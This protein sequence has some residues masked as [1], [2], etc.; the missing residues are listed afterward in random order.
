[1]NIPRPVKNLIEAFERLPGIGPKTARR[2]AFYLLYVPESE[3]DLLAQAV[4]ELREKITFCEIC[5]NVDEQS[6]CRICTSHDRDRSVICV[7]EN[8][9]DVLAIEATTNYKGLYHVLHGVISP[10]N[11]IGPED[12]KVRE[13]LDRVKVSKYQR[14]KEVILAL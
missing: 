11:H 10:I 13:L 7:V 14:V 1:M 8:P 3:V 5:F 4:A 6:P 12:L 9:L 2:L